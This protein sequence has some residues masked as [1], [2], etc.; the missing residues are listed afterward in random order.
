MGVFGT[1]AAGP[2]T[3]AAAAVPAGTGAMAAII[4]LEEATVAAICKQAVTANDE[5]V[6]PANFNSIG[7]IVVAGHKEPVLRAITLA[8][9]QGAKLA[10]LIPVSVPSHCQLMQPAALRLTKLLAT[11]TLRLP[12]IPVLLTGKHFEDKHMPKTFFDRLSSW[13]VSRRSLYRLIE[14][15]QLDRVTTVD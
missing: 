11:I 15:Y 13:G 12:E 9:E 4:G 7:Q 10:V 2:G 14:K 6:S 5:I 8:K 1:A 3:G